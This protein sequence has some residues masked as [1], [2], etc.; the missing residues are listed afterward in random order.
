MIRYRL[1]CAASVAGLACCA[2]VAQ[3]RDWQVSVGGQ[4][5]ASPR[6]E[7]ADG[8]K[9]RASPTFS[10][11]P[12]NRPWRFTPPDGGTSFALVSSKHLEFGPIA[13]FRYSRKPE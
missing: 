9:V 11:Q 1:I 7:G 4:V 12:A 5:T 10:I 8:T 6:Y 2:G 13:R 3:A